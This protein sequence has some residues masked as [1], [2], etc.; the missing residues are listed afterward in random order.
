MKNGL[1]V[2]V[3]LFVLAACSPQSNQDKYNR[4]VKRE[5]A[6][7]KRVDSIFFDIRLGMSRKDFYMY[8]WEMNKKELFFEGIGNMYVL[9]KLKNQL[10]HPAS[11]NFYPDF[12]DSTIWRMRTLFQYDGWV[13]WN[14]KLSADS[15]LPDVVLLYKKWYNS[16]NPFIELE[17]GKTGMKYV[18]V[19]GN[20][21]ITIRKSD[22][23][24]VE[25]YYTD[26]RV[27]NKI[28][29]KDAH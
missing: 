22:D 23:V 14:K 5:L 19:D 6:S 26:M 7:Q 13:P 27:E 15:L 8:C 25:A 20:R 10:H 29:P 4:L 18:K 1:V 24:V 16:G 21:R 17:D 9:Y 28:K 11:M 12:N 3:L 2:F